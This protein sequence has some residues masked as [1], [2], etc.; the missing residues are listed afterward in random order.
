MALTNMQTLHF[1]FG[2]IQ[3]FIAQSRR[4]RDSWAASYLL[5]YLTGCAMQA[6][7][8]NNSASTITFPSVTGDPLYRAIKDGVKPTDPHEPAARVGS[9]PTRFKASVSLGTDG[10]LCAQAIRTKW[11]MIADAVRHALVTDLNF[12]IHPGTWD[13]QID[14]FWD[15]V[16]VLDDDDNALDLRK[17]FRTHLVPPEPGEKCTLCGERQEVTGKG[18]GTASRRDMH[19]AWSTLRETLAL[20]RDKPR[21]RQSLEG[22][23]VFDLNEHERLCAVCLVKRVFPLPKIAE[24]QIGWKLLANYPSTHYFAA[25]DWITRVLDTCASDPDFKKTVTQFI[26][27]AHDAGVWP[28]ER[29]TLIPRIEHAGKGSGLPNWKKFAELDGGAFFKSVLDNEQEFELKKPDR[30]GDLIKALAAIQQALPSDDGL[31]NKATP[32]YALLLMDGDGMGALLSEYS[33]EQSRITAALAQFCNEVRTKVIKNDGY[34]IYAGGDDVFA[35]LPLDRAIACATQCHA[36]YLSA[37]RSH[38]PNI[39]EHRTTISAAI[40]FAHMQTAFGV[41]VHDAHTLLDDIA[42]NGCGRDGLACRVWKRGGPIL[43]WAQPWEVVLRTA[44]AASNHKPHTDIIKE[45]SY[46]FQ[47][48]SFNSP[49]SFS[50]KFFYKLYDVFD[51]LDDQGT[52][53][54]DPEAA[55]KLLAAEY[56]ANRQQSWPPKTSAE[57][58]RQFAEQAVERLLNLCQQQRRVVNTSGATLHAGALSPDG[59]LLIRFLVQKEV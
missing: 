27:T 50:S 55:K 29:T 19:A 21:I 46:L 47:G 6:L 14:H 3:G 39:P 53:N 23:T 1:S 4:T 32:F 57:D 38:T 42:K 5:S 49:P 28:S 16:W 9:L 33:T 18:M 56:L 36:A 41:V 44:T 54:G 30:R 51:L 24:S 40:E 2:P 10:D 15:C 48:K 43:T 17:N 25:I 45:V 22:S 35:L 7:Q 11:T 12:P 34:L 26:E 58:K 31:P 59:A 37:F 52:L 8:D 13:R 20:Q